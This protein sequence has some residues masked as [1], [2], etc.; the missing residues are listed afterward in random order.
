[1]RLSLG[2]SRGRLMGRLLTESLLLAGM[3]GGLGYLFACWGSALLVV[4]ISPANRPL[5][6]NI[7]A[8]LRIFGF[9][10]AACLFTTIRFG[11]A[12]AW[13][14]LRID[15]TP[16]LKQNAQSSST[17][18]LRLNLGKALVVAQVAVSLLLLF[19]AGL[20]VRALI[21]LRHFDPGFD[22]NNVLIVGLNPTRAGYKPSALNDFF[23]RVQ[24]RIAALPGVISATASAS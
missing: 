11:V 22:Q 12:P 17:F 19:G 20:F 23:S 3:G 1:V 21:N 10:A 4:L 5:S 24:Q 2:A 8:D 6:L 18:G 13:R 7:N 16:A 15:I 14:S 9:T